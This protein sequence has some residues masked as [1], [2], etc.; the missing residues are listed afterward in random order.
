VD[1]FRTDMNQTLQNIVN[2]LIPLQQIDQISRAVYVPFALVGF[3]ILCIGYM[4]AIHRHETPY[5]PLGR[6]IILAA[7]IGAAPWFLAITQDI[8]TGLVNAIGSLAGGSWEVTPNSNGGLAMNWTSPYKQLG[9]FVAGNFPDV[10]GTQ[11]WEFGKWFTYAVQELLIVA[12]AAF[13]TV[14]II[15]MQLILIVQRIIILMSGPIMPLAIAALFLPAAQ[16]SA[17]KLLKGIVGVICWPIGWGIASIG[18]MAALKLLKAPTWGSNPG[19]IMV[20]LIPF[21][22]VCVW[23]SLSAVGAPAIISASVTH[24]TNAVASMVGAAAS[25][26]AYQATNAITGGSRIVGAASGNSPAGVDAGAKSGS[27]VGS[28]LAFP[29]SGVGQSMSGFGGSGHAAPSN[30]SQSVADAA[31]A[32]IKNRIEG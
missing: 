4:M 6:F 24:G 11:W 5:E 16:G 2:T 17:Q 9:T 23:M 1:F 10:S 22:V 12:T 26:A 27:I 8:V 30:H 3:F 21:V 15:I 18:W 14:T 7:A 29:L 13:A 25:V 32:A 31:I 20:A 19:S 28:A